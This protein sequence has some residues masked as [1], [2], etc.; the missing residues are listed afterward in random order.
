MVRC[1]SINNFWHIIFFVRKNDI[2]KTSALA[3]IVT[4]GLAVLGGW[5]VVS[6]KHISKLAS[7]CCSCFTELSF[8]LGV[9]IASNHLYQF[10]L[11]AII[12][13]YALGSIIAV[14]CISHFLKGRN[15]I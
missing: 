12:L 7:T 13:L 14:Y 8:K 6:D 1:V 10:I 11:F 15:K 3:N 4:I 2:E 9:D 5:I